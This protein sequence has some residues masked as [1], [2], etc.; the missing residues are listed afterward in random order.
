V[1]SRENWSVFDVGVGG[2]DCGIQNVQANNTPGAVIYTETCRCTLRTTGAGVGNNTPRQPPPSSINLTGTSVKLA[3][4]GY[5]NERIPPENAPANF[6][7]NFNGSAVGSAATTTRTVTYATGGTAVMQYANITAIVN[8]NRGGT[9]SIANAPVHTWPV[10]FMFVIEE[11]DNF[12]LTA[13]SVNDFFYGR[14]NVRPP[15]IIVTTTL[16]AIPEGYHHSGGG[17][18]GVSIFGG[19]VDGPDQSS[20]SYVMGSAS[21]PLTNSD[22]NALTGSFWPTIARGGWGRSNIPSFDKNATQFTLHIVPLLRLTGNWDGGETGG[23]LIFSAPVEPDV[24]PIP[25]VIVDTCYDDEE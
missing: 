20:A 12:P 18:G 24:P 17:M 13:M 3:I 9:Y 10:S 25:P 2:W 14:S 6:N 15:D 23:W 16:P 8:A 22:G 19:W 11:G 7:I 4:I 5:Q 1:V 21:G